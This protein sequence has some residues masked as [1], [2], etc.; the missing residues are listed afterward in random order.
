MSDIEIKNL[1]LYLVVR[2]S[3][4]PGQKVFLKGFIDRLHVTF[5]IL[6]ILYFLYV[7]YWRISYTYGWHYYTTNLNSLGHCIYVHQGKISAAAGLE[8]GTP[9]LCRVNH[10]Y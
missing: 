4:Q 3:F 10:R 9:G 5:D 6:V 2:A 8:P 1:L 7:F